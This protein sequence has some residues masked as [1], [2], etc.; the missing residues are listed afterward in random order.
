[1]R[2]VNT[3]GLAASLL[4]LLSFEMGCSYS[5]ERYLQKGNELF[6]AGKYEDASINYRNAIKKNSQFAEAYQKLGL[7]EFAQGGVDNAIAALSR[8]RQL[9]PD[10]KS[11]LEDLADVTFN[12]YL[13]SGRGQALYD[14]VTGMVKEILAKNPDSAA[15]LR[16]QASL[17]YGDG[18]LHEA[19]DTYAK[20]N[21]LQPFDPAVV[22]PW[23]EALKIDGKPAEAEQ[24]ALQ[25][26][27][28]SP[29]FSPIY[30]WLSNHYTAGGRLAEAEKILKTRIDKNP[31]DFQ[32][33]LSLAA[34]YRN[35][36]KNKEA[37]DLLEAAT[38]RSKDIPDRYALAGNFYVA[39]KDWANAERYYQAGMA[40][41]PR[42]KADYLTKIG[43]I[44]IMQKRNAEA[45]GR[46]D[47]AVKEQPDN[48]RAQGLRISLM[49]D[50]DKPEQIEQ[51]IALAKALALKR[52]SDGR[53][54]A[55][56]ARAYTWKGDTPLAASYYQLAARLDKQFLEPR[57]AL[58]EISKGKRDFTGIFRYTEQVLEVS[59]QDLQ[60]RLLHAW[61]WMG[62]G[63]FTDA[64]NEM[65]T[66]TKDFPD[67]DDVKLQAGLL[68]LT[69]K[70]T[71][72]CIAV[73]EKLLQSRPG[74]QRV[75]AGLA[76]AYVQ[77]GSPD[78]A[79]Q[80]VA[81]EVQ[82]DPSS[83]P[84][85]QLLG[86]MAEKLGRFDVALEQF[87]ALAQAHPDVSEYQFE[88]GK[89]Y[90]FGGDKKNALQSFQAAQ[91]LAPQDAT[92]E[93]RL[94]LAYYAAGLVEQADAAYSRSLA[95]NP[96]DPVLL[97]NRAYFLA[98]TGKNPDEALRLAQSALLKIPD[99]PALL[100]TLAFS[101]IKKNKSGNAATI[102]ERLVH[103]YP[104]EAMF[105][106]HLAMALADTGD[107]ARAVKEL[108]AGLTKHPSKEDQLKIKDL[109][110]K[111]G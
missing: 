9:A 8:A 26:A 94:A 7:C 108:E 22:L 104:D 41:E 25:L 65:Q 76:T 83:V 95:L 84:K 71:R 77:Q 57:L 33:V 47:E 56:L 92:K 36:H 78:T 6:A 17:L 53:F 44:F 20:V 19:I 62:Q 21:T 100:D 3:Y 105:R 85:R 13:A 90:E 2:A 93:G 87:Q 79:I 49:L 31:K 72:A 32:A 12:R 27:A 82:K 40:T 61:G 66:L 24:L 11:I 55:L 4:F 69:E 111:L 73:F 97:N 16:L 30:D 23:A 48:W 43:S 98:E 70:K 80:L 5:Q 34:F 39:G 14:L 67:S 10:N 110:S 38:A 42:L 28:H 29:E 60:A 81:R 37:Q 68:Y 88:V 51:S 91:R 35:Q 18:K 107:R 59:P 63:F 74:D 101:Y 64:E 50:S 46:L 52:P 96:S 1:M 102:L 109:L 75:L 45:M 54:P 15:G 106:Y 103:D 89:L 58:A 99:N 86:N